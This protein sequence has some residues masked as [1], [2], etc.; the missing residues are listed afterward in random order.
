M[1][2]NKFIIFL[3]LHW[4][5]MILIFSGVLFLVVLIALLYF[6]FFN[7]VNLESFSRKQ[8]MAQMGIY[9]L[10]GII[11]AVIFTAFYGIMYY[12]MFMGGGMARM[13][14]G[15]SAERAQPNVHWDEVIGME[16]AKRDAWE[17]VELLKDQ[18]KLKK[19]G[20]NIV[21]GTL[22]L[23]PPGC[24]KTYLAKAIATEAQLPF[25]SASGSEFV[26]M[27]VGQGAARMKSLFKKAR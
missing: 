11:Q 19:I 12:F 7:F 6:G 24:G 13:L 22:F 16:T 1:K 17:I 9:L 8:M 20:G 25:L 4:L 3:R 5:N 2:K 23:C 18:K 14:G 10:M 26:G 21:K 15:D 27:I